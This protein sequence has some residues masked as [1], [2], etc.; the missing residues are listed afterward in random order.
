MKHVYVA[1]PVEPFEPFAQS[2]PSRRTE[3]T[4][5]TAHPT[6][7]DHG[8]RDNRLKNSD[9]ETV[10]CHLPDG[11]PLRRQ[12]KVPCFGAGSLLGISFSVLGFYVQ[13]TFHFASIF[14]YSLAWSCLTSVASYGFFVAISS[15]L[16]SSS[17]DED[18]YS[19]EQVRS[20][21][22]CFALGVFLG[23]CTTCTVTDVLLGMPA[24][25]IL[26]TVAVAVAWALVMAACGGGN[27]DNTEEEAEGENEDVGD[28][29]A[30]VFIPQKET[31]LPLIIV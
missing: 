22:Y 6:R 11:G 31:R 2:P 26:L 9:K 27:N 19:Q 10:S 18:R 17:N 7:H 25:N 8:A 14:G 16:S 15:S 23:F 29:L 28:D 30:R 21:E 4:V 24:K 13:E 5:D 12:H 20:M 3:P 1:I